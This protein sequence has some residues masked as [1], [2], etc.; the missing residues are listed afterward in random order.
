MEGAMKDIRKFRLFRSART[1]F[2][3][4]EIL[5]AATIM[6]VISLGVSQLLVS[7]QR[8]VSKSDVFIGRQ[9]LEK[10]ITSMALSE[11]ARCNSV[12]AGSSAWSCAAECIRCNVGVGCTSSGGNCR[13]H[14]SCGGGS[15]FQTG[16]KDFNSSVDNRWAGADGKPGWSI[17][18]LTPAPGNMVTDDGTPCGGTYQSQNSACRWRVMATMQPD[19]N[20]AIRYTFTVRYAPPDADDPHKIPAR[21]WDV[22]VPITELCSTL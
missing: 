20:D 2:T 8:N 11:K 18:T 4:V 13:N 9:G 21:T 1:G 22:V 5:I 19:F 7:S 14:A 15:S 17:I 6:L 16:I 3:V 10:Y 12:K